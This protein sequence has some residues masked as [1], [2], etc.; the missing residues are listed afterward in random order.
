MAENNMSGKDF[1][2]GAVVGAALGAITAL[3]LAPKSG[4]ELRG[5]IAHQYHNVSEK[6]QEIAGVVKNKSLELAEKAKEVAA[7]VTN[8]IKQWR[9]SRKEAATASEIVDQDAEA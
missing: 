5:D 1:L 4:K 7:T 3:L 2:L 6:T 9:D 8:D